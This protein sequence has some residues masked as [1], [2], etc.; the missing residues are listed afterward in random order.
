MLAVMVRNL[1]D[2]A[3][4][5]IPKGGRIDI[6]VYR[7]ET[8]AILQIEDNGPGIPEADLAKIFEPFVRGRGVVEEGSGLGL[9]IVK[10]IVRRLDGSLSLENIS[11]T[12]ASGLRVIVTL[13]A[14]DQPTQEPAS[15]PL[16]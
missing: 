15:A 13:P 6:G 8:R 14:L 10:R 5:H 2:N 16:A 11:G 12:A 4:R 7:E 1:I 3:I 9:S